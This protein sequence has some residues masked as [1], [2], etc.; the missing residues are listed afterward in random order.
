[1]AFSFIKLISSSETLTKREAAILKIC[2][3]SII[4]TAEVIS[5][6][7]LTSEQPRKTKMAFGGILSQIKLFFGPLVIQL[8]WYILKQLVIFTILNYIF[9][10]IYTILKTE[11]YDYVKKTI[12]AR[13]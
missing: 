9:E 10:N 7:L 8:V 2:P 5:Q 12:L 6:V 3:P 1:M 13:R 4:T 11:L